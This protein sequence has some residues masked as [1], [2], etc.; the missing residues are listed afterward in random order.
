MALSPAVELQVKSIAQVTGTFVALKSVL[1]A[2]L[3][4][5]PIEFDTSSNLLFSNSTAAAAGG[6][7]LSQHLA[8][9]YENVLKKSCIWDTVFH[10]TG[11]MRPEFDHDY[12][13][14][15][16]FG[17]GWNRVI[18]FVSDALFKQMDNSYEKYT[19][20]AIFTS[21]ASHYIGCILFYYLTMLVYPTLSPSMS[22]GV[23]G[24]G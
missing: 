11:A 6:D 24:T 5:Q 8:S 21:T 20:G 2:L 4:L 9:F 18:R 19:L 1:F 23:G 17:V 22:G 12:E 7:I 15:W 14:E 13:H 10:V 3:G 16:A